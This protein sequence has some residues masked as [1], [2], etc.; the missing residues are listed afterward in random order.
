MRSRLFSLFLFVLACSISAVGQTVVESASSVVLSDSMA[1]FRLAVENRSKSFNGNLDVEIIDATGAVRAKSQQQVR[2][3]SGRSVQKIS[4]ALGDL[5]KKEGDN[6]AWFRFRY[7]LG[8]STGIISMSEL[9]KADFEL[10][11]SAYQNSSSGAPFLVRV[12]A[13]NPYTKEAVRNVHVDASLKFELDLDATENETVVKATGETNRDGF[14]TLKFQIP[15]GAKIGGDRELTV[16]GRK[17]GI[18]RSIEENLESSE[19]K[20]S[21]YI[22]TDKPIYQPGQHFNVRAL[23]FDANNTVVSKTGLEFKIEDE[24]DTVLYREKVETSGFGIASISWTIPENAKL[25][26]YRV[27]IESDNEIQQN[28]ISFKVTRYDL[29]NFT[30]STKADKSF[31]LPKD[32]TAEITVGAEYLFG[33]PVHSGNVRLVQE[34]GRHWNW[35]TQKYEADEKPAIEGHA[36]ANGRYTAKVDITSEMAD[37]NANHWERYKDLSFAA[38]FTDASTNRTEQ[39]RFEIRLTKEPIHIYLMRY[40]NQNPH[41]PLIAYVST[42]YA[43]GK[44]AVCNVEVKDRYSVLR[45]IKTNSLGAGRLEF[46]IPTDSVRGQRF[47]IQIR[48]VDRSGG[49]GTFEEDFYLTDEDV[50]QMKTPQA[51]IQ[52]GQVIPVS[53][54]STQK[55][56]FLY[57]DVIKDRTP[58]DT[59]VVEL[60]GGK[61][62]FE[63][64]YRDEFK[65]ELTVTAYSDRSKSYWDDKM[66]TTRGVVYPS[67][68]NLKVNAKFSASQYKP[69]QDATVKFSIFDGTGRSTESALGIA[70][71]DK[72]IEE[73]AK[74]DEQFGSYFSRYFRLLGYGR[75]FGDLSLRDLNELDPNKPVSPDLQLAAEIMLADNY[76]YPQIYRSEASPNEAKDLYQETFDA[77]IKPIRDALSKQYDSNWQIAV[78]GQSLRTIMRSNGTDFDRILDPWGQKYIAAFSIDRSNR[79]VSI[80][81]A[82]PDKKPNTADDIRIYSGQYGYFVSVG[83]AIDTAVN[84]FQLQSET[85]IRNGETLLSVLAAKG[86]DR[87]QLTD[88]WGRP[89]QIL[90]EVAG[91]N[92]II[93]LRSSGPNGVFESRLTYGDDFEIWRTFSDYFQRTDLK[94]NRVLSDAVNLNK[95]PF[96]ENEQQFKKILS[97]GGIRLDSI[98]DGYGNPVY[99]TSEVETRYTDKTTII[100]GKQVIRPATTEMRIFRIRSNGESAIDRSDDQTLATYSGAIT[101]SYRDNDFSK[102]TVN[103]VAFSGA[104]GAIRGSVT[105]PNGAVVPSAT[106]TATDEGGDAKSFTTATNESG[107]F[108]IANLPSGRYMLQITAPGFRRYVQKGIEVRSQNLI[109]VKVSLGVGGVSEVVSVTG[110]SDLAVNTSD[111]ATSTTVTTVTKTNTRISFPYKEQNA[112]PRVREYF[113]E[114]LVWQPELVTDVN[115]RA[116][117]KFKTADNITTWKMYTIASTKN[118]KV[119]VAEKELTSFQPFFVDLD[120]PKFL[121]E[122]DEIYLPT[123]VRNYTD[124]RQQVDVTM[125]KADWFTFLS[126][127]KQRISV[128]AGNSNNSIFGFK[129]VS[130]VKDGKQRVTAIAQTDSDAIERPVTVRPDGQEIVRTDSRFAAG[131]QRLDLAF[132]A[133][134]LPRTQKAELKI[135]PNL[136]SH[137]AESVEGLLHRPY[138]C[139]E[140]TISSTYPNLMI[141]KFVRPDAVI[142]KKAKNY[143]QKG[144]GR[145][146]GYQ[147]ADG[148]F[149]YW[150]GKDRSDIALTAYAIRF[151]SDAGSQI[152]VDGDVIKRASDWLIKQ[153]RADGSWSQG[154]VWETKEDVKRTKLLTTYIARSLAMNKDSDKNALKKALDYL[155]VRNDEIDEPYALALYGLASLDAG[156][157]DAAETVARRLESMAISE[158]DGVY[159]NL[160]TNTPFYGWGTAGR[161]ETTALVTHLL[162]RIGKDAPSPKTAGLISKGMIFLLKNKDRYGVWYSTQTTIKVLDAFVAAIG[163]SKATAAQQ[164]NVTLN[165]Q[166][167][168]TIDV[169][170]DR[171]E[172]VII[173]LTGK[174]EAAANSIEVRS[175]SADP[176]MTQVVASHYIDWK[177]ADLSGRTV[178][179]SR[180]LR[181]GYKCDKQTAAIMQEVTCSVEAERVAFQGYGMLLAEIGTPPG[182]DVSRESLEKAIGDDWNISRYDILPDRIV[183]YM[184]ARPGGTKFSFKFKPRYAINA[185][186]PASVVYDYYNPE[187]QAT[188]VPLRFAVR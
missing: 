158:G 75:S 136:Y 175:T 138:G 104:Q 72:A 91:R 88:P 126:A 102:G 137:V 11:A 3:T 23:Y 68:Q 188:A 120:P 134:A 92:Y 52:P 58:I 10:Q 21:L 84:E 108:L 6:I 112:T 78:D 187:A 106:V 13:L 33:K 183:V 121:T 79:V 50:L 148:G 99:L 129:A 115:G 51:I 90:V 144:Y 69:N 53:L 165:G 61:S 76:Y 116:E 105:D 128:D 87:T 63:I 81:S 96:P 97:D 152:N 86:I 182:A 171:I 143:L 139:G 114:T 173:D 54:R 42:F 36:D 26:A 153:Q 149:T 123:Q 27:V 140:Q 159:W 19:S 113:P 47:P 109:E 35:S 119:G 103:T 28:E 145:L 65:G 44:V 16:D 100:N 66:R 2:V 15:A 71:F 89:Y 168:D 25:G 22:T 37:L 62:E 127:D 186:T 142:A 179:Q 85:Y 40:A 122:G 41:L 163:T 178:N 43:D 45:R 180:A 132:P 55:D 155:R 157:R 107:D 146:L 29:P 24:D 130:P 73:R 176:M 14:V 48:A 32:H 124:K 147:V 101:E 156:D 64:P 150:G 70:I 117:L 110:D 135:F 34:S 131:T 82:G 74:T 167:F 162:V 172:P 83:R 56:G 181:L 7:H 4:V 46:E 93:R 133:N 98:V 169:A 30:V 154:Y 141:L 94:I 8:D 177:D 80:L 49:T 185:Q 17:N 164:L 60:H 39:R 59:R 77:Q 170:A 161:I 18:K 151:L 1:D 9:I 67:P 160:E 174:L 38:Y 5:L 20:G 166:P 118:G 184:W 12:R 57:V 111:A 125:A 95:R 31:Y